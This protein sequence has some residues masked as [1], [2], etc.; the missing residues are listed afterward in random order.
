MSY[1]LV[2]RDNGILLGHCLGMLFWSKL[3]PVG[4]PAAVTFPSQA[5]V[6]RALSTW[7]APL[8]QERE[9]MRLH[10]VVADDGLY[11]TVASCAAAGLEPWQDEITPVANER[12]C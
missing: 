7:L 1:V 10:E 6:D 5:E 12:P 11:A 8:Q 4:Q 3:D 2:H 9:H